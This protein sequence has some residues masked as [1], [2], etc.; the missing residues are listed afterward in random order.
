MIF[1]LGILCFDFCIEIY[2]E[3]RVNDCCY[4]I[5]YR[6][7]RA[8]KRKLSVYFTLQRR[9]VWMRCNGI[10]AMERVAFHFIPCYGCCGMV[11]FLLWAYGVVKQKGGR[12]GKLLLI[13]DSKRHTVLLSELFPAISTHLPPHVSKR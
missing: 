11:W 12:E 9:A 13:Y 1:F 2:F 7:D 4:E 8:K 10:I 6:K 5:V 3:R